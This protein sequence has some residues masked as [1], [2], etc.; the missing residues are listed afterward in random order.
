MPYNEQESDFK[1]SCDEA[2]F[3]ANS[4]FYVYDA[5]KNCYRL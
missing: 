5:L 2:R 1:A 4:H 3:S